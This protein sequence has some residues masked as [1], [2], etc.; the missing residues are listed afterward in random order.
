MSVIFPVFTVH[1]CLPLLYTEQSLRERRQTHVC[2]HPEATSPLA[3]STTWPRRQ[4]GDLWRYDYN[5]TAKAWQQT[6]VFI[7]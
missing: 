3:T 5:Q 4:G 1:S 2:R 7:L 6:Q